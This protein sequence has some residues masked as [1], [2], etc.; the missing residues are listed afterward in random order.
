MSIR[1][2]EPGA[3]TT[4]QDLGRPGYR[5]AGV[6]PS[7]A[8]DAPALRLANRLV[9]N[10]DGAAAL[11][12]TMTGPTLAFEA[13]AVVAFAGAPFEVRADRGRFGTGGAFPVEAGTTL[14]IA[15]ATAGL[16]GYL[17]VRGGIDVPAVLG[18]RSTFVSGSIGGVRGAALKAGDFLRV[19]D[20]GNGPLR[21]VRSF[22]SRAGGGTVRAMPGTH[23]DHFTSTAAE[24]FWAGS[25]RVSPRSDRAG[26]RLTGESLA[27]GGASDIDPEAVVFGDVQ[28]TS[29]GLPIVLGPDGPATGG[30]AK[31]ATVIGADL[32]VI[33]Q[34]RPGDTLRFVQVSLDEARTAWRES[35]RALADA[36]EAST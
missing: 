2:V 3:F 8:M 25:Y 11:E 1:V 10:D 15:R 5:S 16:R 23:H 24:R 20:G 29:D 18:S 17:A 13:D 9:G 33:A 14:R 34:A 32:P 12:I 35:D 27:L 30:Y 4:V 36:I 7:G 22:P 6:P 31:I 21:H 28:I 26:V 19:G